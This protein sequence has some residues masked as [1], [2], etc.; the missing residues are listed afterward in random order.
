MKPKKSYKVP[1]IKVLILKSREQLMQSSGS[2]P[3]PAGFRD[4]EKDYYA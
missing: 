3:G 2:Y 1:E 4:G